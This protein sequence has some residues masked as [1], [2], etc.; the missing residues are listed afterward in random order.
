MK[1]Q[2]IGPAV[3][4][5]TLFYRKSKSHSLSSH[6]CIWKAVFSSRFQFLSFV[7]F[8]CTNYYPWSFCF[9]VSIC[10]FLRLMLLNVADRAERGAT[11]ETGSCRNVCA[12]L[13]VCLS[14]CVFVLYIWV[15]IVMWLCLSLCLCSVLA[16]VYVLPFLKVLVLIFFS[17]GTAFSI[18]L[19]NI[20]Q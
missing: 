17:P 14:F 7:I 4:S 2:H 16:S 1:C 13:C 5:H 12:R 9:F 6:K 11:F 19:R 10:N 18:K 8:A 15:G 20:W 3:K